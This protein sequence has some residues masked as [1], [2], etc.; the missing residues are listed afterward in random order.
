MNPQIHTKYDR[1]RKLYA[2]IEMGLKTG[3]YAKRDTPDEMWHLYKGDTEW[4]GDFMS[5]VEVCEFAEEN[6]H[7]W[8]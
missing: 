8:A 6:P 1:R 2:L 3:L 7:L 5:L 4:L